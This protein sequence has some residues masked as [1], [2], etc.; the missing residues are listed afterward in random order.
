M[1]LITLWWETPRTFPWESTSKSLIDLSDGPS[2]LAYPLWWLIPYTF[3]QEADLLPQDVPIWI[4][5]IH[6]SSPYGVTI[7]GTEKSYVI[8]LPNSFERY[9]ENLP[10]RHRKSIRQVLRRN[11]DLEVSTG[12]LEDIRS[13]WDYYVQRIDS[14]NAEDGWDPY[15]EQELSA[16]KQFY[17]STRMDIIAFRRAGELV[18]VNI[19][20]YEKDAVY[21]LACFTKPGPDLRRRSIGVF[22]VLMNIERAIGKGIG[23]YD[24]L[25]GSSGYKEQFGPRTV[26]LKH[27][28]CADKKFAAAYDIPE[29]FVVLK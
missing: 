3:P 10:Y 22:A 8:D 17:E 16:R 20:L 21:D 24:L 28:I 14:L 7:P 18:A 29:E 12:S 15:S 5:D 23:V 13:L 6:P 9:V 25:T 11:A 2:Y 26:D 27:Y 19:S 4:P 1:P